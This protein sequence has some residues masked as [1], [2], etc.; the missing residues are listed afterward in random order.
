MLNDEGKRQLLQAHW[1]RNA[2][3]SDFSAAHAIYH[4]DAILEWPQSGERFAGKETLIA[5]R[6]GAPPLEFTTWRIV[7]SGDV[8]RT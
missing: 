1:E 4:E 8:W 5:M 2:N 6:K 3:A 7:G